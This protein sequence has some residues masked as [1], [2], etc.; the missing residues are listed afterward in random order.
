MLLDRRVDALLCGTLCWPGFATGAPTL[1]VRDIEH[2]GSPDVML[3]LYSGGAHCCY[4]TQVYRYDPGTQTYAVVPAP[5]RRPARTARDDLGG[6]SVFLSAD[7]RFAYRFAAFAFSGL[8]LQIWSFASGRF[9]DVTRR[10][11]AR[12]AADAR[13]W[14]K[15]FRANVR[16][17]LGDGALAA[18]AADE[19]LLGRGARDARDARRAGAPRGAA[20]RRRRPGRRRVH[21]RARAIPRADR[22]LVSAVDLQSHSR[23]SDGELEAGE[24]VAAAARAGVEVL[25]L[26]DHDTVDG[27]EEALGAARE[28]G[29]ALVPATEISAVDAG[30]EDLHV[31][32]YGI[33]HPTRAARAAARRARGPRASRASGWARCWRRA[34][35]AV[36]DAPLAARRAAGKPIGRPHLAGAVLAPSRRTRRGSRGRATP[37]S[38]ASSAR[39]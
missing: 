3:S 26:S 16:Q 35:Y 27:V 28:H 36:D 2:D 1:A 21:P 15:A 12:V 31:L 11:P 18:W 10:Y 32:G 30:Y 4:I 17:H 38:R 33:D 25:A 8:P 34:G 24:V 7:D 22:L 13:R 29:V 9:V 37:T 20:Q 5:L 39:G 19:D 23:H 14:W 6:A